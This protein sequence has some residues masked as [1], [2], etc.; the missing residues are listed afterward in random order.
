MEIEL[1]IRDY[2]Y[3]DTKIL[4]GRDL[5]ELI[6]ERV[7]LSKLDYSTQPVILKI[8]NNF[9]SIT[10]SFILGLFGDSIR[11]LGAEGFS[12]QYEI[13]SKEVFKKTIN[14]YIKIIKETKNV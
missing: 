13:Q 6:R 9:I 10:S 5:G 2:I 8:D 3:S 11:D 1:N 7:N 4:T 14:K 12:V